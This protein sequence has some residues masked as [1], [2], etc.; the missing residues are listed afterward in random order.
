[1]RLEHQKYLKSH[2]YTEKDQ[3]YKDYR[4]TEDGRETLRDIYI[5]VKED[6]LN[7]CT[8]I[9]K[10]F[11][12]HD[13]TDFLVVDE[14]DFVDKAIVALCKENDLVLLTNDSDFKHSGLDILTGNP[15]ILTP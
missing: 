11:G 10:S 2:G 13:I 12:I 3:S 6:I 8:V 7:R 1:M 14:L 15:H 9:G 5:T 4:D